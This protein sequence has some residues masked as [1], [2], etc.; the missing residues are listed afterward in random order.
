MSKDLCLAMTNSLNN[1]FF[2]MLLEDKKDKIDER[3]SLLHDI[4]ERYLA[5]YQADEVDVIGKQLLP[6]AFK[7]AST[8][9]EVMSALLVMLN[10]MPGYLN[11]DMGAISAVLKAKEENKFASCVKL[12]L[13]SAHWQAKLDDCLQKGPVTMKIAPELAHLTEKLAM[14]NEASKPKGDED[15]EASQPEQRNEVVS[16]DLNN[17]IDKLEEFQKSLRK[18]ATGAL[19]KE[20]IERLM[21]IAEWTIGQTEVKS[22]PDFHVPALSKGLQLLSK[23][24][25]SLPEFLKKLEA[26]KGNMAQ[27]LSKQ[28]IIS[29]AQVVSQDGAPVDWEIVK[30]LMD[31][32]NDARADPEI[33]DAFRKLSGILFRS[34]AAQ[35]LV[36]EDA[37]RYSYLG[38]CFPNPKAA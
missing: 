27:G 19:E 37:S 25:K 16:A 8:I 15:D 33:V 38:V 21:A 13:K 30:Q 26:W 24:H 11:T 22:L 4:C 2:M 3:M 1:D 31:G 35:A 6:G 18:G 9:K 20:M 5:L 17:A 14:E 29:Y 7:A 23:G 28:K 10:P 32:S 34:L 12:F 36:E